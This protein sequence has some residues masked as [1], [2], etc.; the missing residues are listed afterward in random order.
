MN[1]STVA[2]ALTSILANAGTIGSVVNDVQAIYGEIQQELS[3]TDQASVD[4]ALAAAQ[5]SDAAATQ[6][7]DASLQDAAKA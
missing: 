6:A 7:A 1:L 3:A 4:A 2:S 5:K